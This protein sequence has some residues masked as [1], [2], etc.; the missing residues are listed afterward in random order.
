VK[1]WDVATLQERAT[2]RGH[3]GRIK[4]LAFKADG[5][6]LVSGSEGGTLKLWDMTTR[7]ER[8]TLKGHR[9]A[10][11]A[12]AFLADGR[13]L[14]SGGADRAVRLWQADSPDGGAGAAP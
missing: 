1:L 14:A 7:Q 2:L 5:N 8:A 12:A 4:C 6:T 13:T 9:G 11:L 10:V 3:T